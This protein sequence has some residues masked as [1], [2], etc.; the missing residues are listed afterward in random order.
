MQV[1]EPKVS[2]VYKF[3]TKTKF[4]ARIDAASPKH[5][6]TVAMRP[7]GIVDTMIPILN[8]KLVSMS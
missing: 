3:F 1:V 7:S 2:T 6:V 4:S 8:V 5:T